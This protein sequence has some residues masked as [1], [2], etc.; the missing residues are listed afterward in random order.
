MPKVLHNWSRA[1]GYMT[2]FKMTAKHDNLHQ[3]TPNIT[4]L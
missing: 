4:D 3:C 1:E 2:F